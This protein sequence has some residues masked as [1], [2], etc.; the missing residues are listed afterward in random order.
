MLAVRGRRASRRDPRAA[1]QAFERMRNTLSHTFQNLGTPVVYHTCCVATLQVEIIALILS[2]P[3]R[4]SHIDRDFIVPIKKAEVVGKADISATLDY[5]QEL[6]DTGVRC[7]VHRYLRV[8]TFGP[9]EK[10]LCFFVTSAHAQY[11]EPWV[12]NLS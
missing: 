7:C 5:T 1:S 3:R 12:Q 2:N 8:P 6:G 4:R 10:T 11:T 9:I